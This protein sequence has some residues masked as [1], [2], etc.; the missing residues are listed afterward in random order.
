[1]PKVSVNVVIAPFTA[2]VNS[3]PLASITVPVD[4][5]GLGIVQPLRVFTV[6][7]PPLF[8]TVTR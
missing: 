2:V 8:V 5:P 6:T 1:V 3:F 7:V 4:V